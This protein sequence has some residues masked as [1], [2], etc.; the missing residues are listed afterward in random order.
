MSVTSYYFV[1]VPLC[2]SPLSVRVAV[3]G[4][5]LTVG[6]VVVVVDV[7]VVGVVKT[8]VVDVDEGVDVSGVDAVCVDVMEL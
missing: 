2:H 3:T 7:V 5:L 8:V 1:Q 4:G 6:N